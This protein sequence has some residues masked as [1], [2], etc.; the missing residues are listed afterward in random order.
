MRSEI[1]PDLSVILHCQLWPTAADGSC[2]CVAPAVAPTWAA[3]H[4]AGKRAT[5]DSHPLAVQN[6]RAGQTIQRPRAAAPAYGLPGQINTG[7]GLSTTLPCQQKTRHASLSMTWHVWHTR[8]RPPPFPIT[9][10]RFIPTT[11]VGGVSPE[12]Q[13]NG[14]T[15][16][17]ITQLKIYAK[18]RLGTSCPFAVAL[19]FPCIQSCVQSVEVAPVST[20]PV[21]R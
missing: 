11:G 9:D 17:K 13:K 8:R 2:L 16:L 6:C 3:R 20:S 10:S 5:Q 7:T 15:L 14:T 19:Y 4:T 12:N 21:D 1:R 18:F